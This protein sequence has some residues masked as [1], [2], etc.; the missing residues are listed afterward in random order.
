MRKSQGEFKSLILK[1]CS[2]SNS[3][4]LK[5]FLKTPG[6]SGD[7]IGD[8]TPGQALK[9]FGGTLVICPMDEHLFSIYRDRDSLGEMMEKVALGPFYLHLRKIAGD[10]H[11]FW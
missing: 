7:H 1:I 10:P 6:N 2:E 4:N 3:D 5:P 9:G 11:L 8:E